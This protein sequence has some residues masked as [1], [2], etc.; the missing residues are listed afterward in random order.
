MLPTL[1]LAV[2]TDFGGGFAV[3]F[4]VSFDLTISAAFLPAGACLASDVTGAFPS[5]GEFL[6]VQ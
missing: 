2:V 1:D 6:A 5:F 4:F 3:G